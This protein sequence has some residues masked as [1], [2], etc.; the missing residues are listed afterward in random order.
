MLAPPAGGFHKH[1]LQFTRHDLPDAMAEPSRCCHNHACHYAH[2]A[3]CLHAGFAS[4]TATL[5]PCSAHPSGFECTHQLHTSPLP[6]SCGWPS[7]GTIALISLLLSAHAPALSARTH[8][9]MA[10]QATA[11]IP[12]TQSPGTVQGDL[13]RWPPGH[14]QGCRHLHRPSLAVLGHIAT[15]QG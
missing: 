3:F 2:V 14:L 12:A 15:L 13:N 1:T 5:G 7:H 4:L 9:D 8:Q 11:S 10:N 6:T